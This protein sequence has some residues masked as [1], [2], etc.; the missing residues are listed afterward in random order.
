MREL[1]LNIARVMVGS[2]IGAVLSWLLITWIGNGRFP[3]HQWGDLKTYAAGGVGCAI[4]VGAGYYL[5][6]YLLRLDDRATSAV[7][8]IL[9]IST[10][11][12]LRGV[13][14]PK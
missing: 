12:F 3:L 14:V 7:V 2:W 6:R 13:M 11:A 9:L 1:V 10:V 8:L 4:I 5:S